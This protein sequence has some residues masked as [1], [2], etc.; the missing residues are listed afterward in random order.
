MEHI[1]ID[2]GSRESQVCVRNGIGEILRK[3]AAALTSSDD[4]WENERQGASCWRP[5]RKPSGS[6]A[7]HGSRDMMCGWW[8][9]AWS[10]RWA[11]ASG[12]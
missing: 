11:S 10:A 7:G 8:R 5:A 2:L 12:D 4:T 9:R 1:G 6:P 3:S